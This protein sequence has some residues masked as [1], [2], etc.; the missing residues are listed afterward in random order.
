MGKQTSV[1]Y[2]AVKNNSERHNLAEVRENYDYI[3]SDLAKDNDHWQSHSIKEVKDHIKDSY[4]KSVGQKIQ[5]HATPI[6]EAVVVIKEDTT[7]EELHELAN[8]FEKE[9]GIKTFQINMHKDEGHYNE[10][11]EWIPNYH[12]H[13]VTA[14]NALEDVYKEKEDGSKELSIKAGT[15]LKIPTIAFNQMQTM[16]SETLGMDRGTTS[17][18]KHISAKKYK[19]IIK[20]Q[21][22]H[23]KALNDFSPSLKNANKLRKGELVQKAEELYLALDKAL[24]DNLTLIE[25]GLNHDSVVEQLRNRI[26]DLDKKVKRQDNSEA[27]IKYLKAELESVQETNSRWKKLN[28]KLTKENAALLSRGKGNNLSQ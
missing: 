3:R 23:E 4:L 28:D 24:N 9:W 8:R 19:A 21:K 20:A 22:A 18:K 13:F 12:A 17:N 6:R 1:N 10:H 11:K 27:E 25:K 5:P 14:F 15:S 7:M 26:A 2:Q 16:A